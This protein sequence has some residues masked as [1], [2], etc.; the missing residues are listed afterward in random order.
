M[1]DGANIIV[2]IYRPAGDGPFPTLV[3]FTPYGRT[4]PS[5]SYAVDPLQVCRAGLA[6]IV[7][8]TRGRF[9]SDGE[10]QP[11]RSEHE[12]L[13]DVLAWFRAQSWVGDLFLV[14]GSYGGTLHW[15]SGHHI[16]E[17]VAAMTLYMCSPDFSSWTNRNGLFQ[18]GFLTY[19]ALN[20]LLIHVSREHRDQMIELSELALSAPPTA[21]TMAQIEQSVPWYPAWRETATAPVVPSSAV[22]TMVITGWFD[23]FK[24]EALN[25]FAKINAEN[26]SA[27][28]LVVGP[29]S[30]SNN[31]GFFAERSFGQRA[32]AAAV[33]LA[34]RQI[35]WLKAHLSES[36]S[37]ESVS[38]LLFL[39]G[40]DEWIELA[41]WPPRESPLSL[42]LEVGKPSPL[43]VADPSA[44]TERR[45]LEHHPESPSPT[46]GG[47]VYLAGSRVGLNAGSMR[48]PL[49]QTN[50]RI[51]YQSAQLDEDLPVVGDVTLSLT[52]NTADPTV[53][54]VATLLDIGPDGH[55]YNLTR[56]ATR[57]RVSDTD[58]AS[59]LSISLG[60][61]ANVF[62]AGHRVGLS[63]TTA[64]FPA[65]DPMPTPFRANVLHG[66]VSNSRLQLPVVDLYPN[67]GG[68]ICV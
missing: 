47:N 51:V 20:H 41:S 13:A 3:Q 26:P 31:T 39:M 46:V 40:V 12:D 33:D 21:A 58:V 56:G 16:C 49:D 7:G 24:D 34:G 37:A 68:S 42:W 36:R 5:A 54:I 50:D 2:D 30:H 9:D 60:S 48:Q 10:F 59:E 43:L 44:A 18:Y 38:V 64:N 1:P 61:T 45:V 25:A 63:L 23:I 29:W 6:M 53:D 66:G 15:L 57:V 67:L 4:G 32:S 17:R 27:H 35:E 55:A 22:P 52:I 28:S 8:D 11:F 62:Q 19:W 14:G 65:Y